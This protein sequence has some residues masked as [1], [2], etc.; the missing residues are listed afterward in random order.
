VSLFRKLRYINSNFISVQMQSIPVIIVNWNGFDDTVECI[1]SILNQSFQE[2]TIYLT[3]NASDNDEFEKLSS[4]YNNNPKIVLQ[5]N[6]DNLGFTIAHNSL[7][8]QLKNSNA[9]YIALINNDAVADKHW[10]GNALKKASEVKAQIVACKMI[11]YLNRGIIDSAGLFLLST[12]EILPFH[13]GENC[14]SVPD[15]NNTISAC[16]GACIYQLSMLKEIG[17]FDQYFSTGYEDAELGLRAFLAGKR[18][19]YAPDSIVF[20][21][22]SQSVSK[23]IDK[24]KIQKI[25]EDINYTYLKLMPAGAIAINALI[26]IPRIIIILLIHLITLR[27]KFIKCYLLAN[28][29]TIHDRKLIRAKRSEFKKLRKLNTWDVL[30]AQHFSLAYDLKR[31][32]RYIMN[33]RKN[34]FEKY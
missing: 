9:E 16:G 7:F 6:D 8:E 11:N 20:H 29:K 19:V 27:F 33:G 10:L 17:F 18:I 5:K 15:K 22:I 4:K 23:I 3:D 14:T 21:K 28:I 13:N 24:K 12:G 34:Q 31:F 2:F 1:D 32:Y 30:K 26:N 25:Q